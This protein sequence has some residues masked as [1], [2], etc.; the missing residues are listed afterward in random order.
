MVKLI[1]KSD[2]PDLLRFISG[3]PEYVTF[4]YNQKFFMERNLRLSEVTQL[5]QYEDCV[6]VTSTFY[7]REMKEQ[8]ILD[9]IKSERRWR[10]TALYEPMSR[11][12]F[13]LK[14]KIY[15]V[16]GSWESVHDDASFFELYQALSTPYWY[17]EYFKLLKVYHP[18][19]IL[20]GVI[21]FC[22]KSQNLHRQPQSVAYTKLLVAVQKKVEKNFRKAVKSLDLTDPEFGVMQF[23]QELLK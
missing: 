5:S 1:V 8:D 21:T 16:C 23:I 11:E 7:E 9:F 15:W 4:P 20:S 6:I 18:N 12:E 10:K 2:Y 22:E 19:Q 3:Y 14:A 17:G 13:E